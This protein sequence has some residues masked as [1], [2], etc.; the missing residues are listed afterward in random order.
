MAPLGLAIHTSSPD[1]GLALGRGDGA[2]RHQV[3]PL[4]RDLSTHLHI[5]LQQFIVPHTWADLDFVAVAKGPGGFT[6]TRIGVVVARTLAQQVGV[7]LF[8]VS[9]L[10]VAAQ[11]WWQ[12]QPDLAQT[13]AV[14]LQAQRG[15]WFGGVYTCGAVGKAVD[16]TDPAAPDAAPTLDCLLKDQVMAP[17]QWDAYLQS[18]PTFHR[19]TL[20]GG[21]GH[22]SAAL[23]ALAREQWQRGQRP[24]WDS[25]IPYYGQHPVNH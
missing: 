23:L 21:G 5:H 1:L 2:D 12:Q 18:H 8:G 17:D 4:G 19:L 11:H 13:V 24:A 16:Q 6:G 3:W 7:P 25:V 20:S 15:Q 22:H 14:E 9:S 10:A